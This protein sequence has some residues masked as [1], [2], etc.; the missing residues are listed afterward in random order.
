MHSN[1]FVR[2]LQALFW[3]WLSA[4]YID[5]FYRDKLLDEKDYVR[6]TNI[7][8]RNWYKFP[9]T[10]KK[11]VTIMDIEAGFLE[12]DHLQYPDVLVEGA[13]KKLQRKYL[14]E[15]RHARIA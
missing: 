12:W 1:R 3:T 13:G 2:Y 11:D 5:E 7:L 10:F 9:H 6:I 4:N 14:R 8:K 15:A